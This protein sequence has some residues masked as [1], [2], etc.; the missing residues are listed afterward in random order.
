MSLLEIFIIVFAFF[1]ISS[2]LLRFRDKKVS[3]AETF[4]WLC[5]WLGLITLALIP[6]LLTIF[7]QS[8]GISRPVDF[9]VY[10][11]LVL[12]FYLLFRL[13]V[14]LETLEQDLTKVVREIAIRKKK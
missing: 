7:T 9:A 11:S 14:K 13:Y 3:I 4:F 10:L 1:A 2:V 12:L 5:V 8:V 6:D